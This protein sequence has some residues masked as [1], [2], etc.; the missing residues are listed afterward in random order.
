MGSSSS[1]PSR[2]RAN[3]KGQAGSHGGTNGDPKDKAKG[4]AHKKTRSPG[5]H[6]NDLARP[7]GD[8]GGRRSESGQQLQPEVVVRIGA[9]HPQVGTGTF[10]AESLLSSV[11]A[12]VKTQLEE[13]FHTLEAALASADDPAAA[14]QTARTAGHQIADAV[15]AGVVEGMR[16]RDRHLAQLA[17]IDR[18]AAQAESLKSLRGRISS[19]L[20]L[21]GLRRISDLSDLSA[22]NL[23][24]PTGSQV[25]AHRE[26]EAYELVSPA[27]TDAQTGR[28]VE[29]GWIRR[30]SRE[31]SEGPGGKRHGRRSRLHRTGDEA[32]IGDAS[33]PL[34]MPTAADR[35]RTPRAIECPAR[36]RAEDES[37]PLA[38]D[39]DAPV[40]ER[41][42][43]G[44]SRLEASSDTSASYAAS[45]CD[46]EEGV[47]KSA[48][49]LAGGVNQE[50]EGSGTGSRGESPRRMRAPGA[51][52]GVCP[53]GAVF[54]SK[55][56]AKAQEMNDVAPRRTS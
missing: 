16:V 2:P 11:L 27:Y 55:L 13:G 40:G 45:Q 6:P 23:V 31:Q 10:D 35:E 5:P 44:P 39:G 21:V 48:P 56:L 32:P 49:A 42:H 19:E 43:G 14:A 54:S 41:G 25:A 20:E 52:G 50:G 47:P 53:S 24:E 7:Q 22:F 34:L 51:I 33:G 29:R 46:P 12:A 4:R 37:L 26:G 17:V 1:K 3:G 15:R 38:Q 9:G 28:T 8:G 36:L 30:S 18:A